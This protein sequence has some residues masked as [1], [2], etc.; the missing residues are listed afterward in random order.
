MR[1][2]RTYSVIKYSC[3]NKIFK[4]SINSKQYIHS[5]LVYV[6]NIFSIYYLFTKD[7]LLLCIII[8]E[9]IYIDYF[10]LINKERKN[11]DKM[12]RFFL[13]FQIPIF[14]SS[15]SFFITHKLIFSLLKLNKSHNYKMAAAFRIPTNK[16][17]QKLSEMRGAQVKAAQWKHL[18]HV[19][20]LS[21]WKN[22]FLV[23]FIFAYMLSLFFIVFFFLSII[24]FLGKEPI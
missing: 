24:D 1:P 3:R 9:F 15:P 21:G 19:P 23:R 5:F 6:S 11:K 2:L 13:F 20:K 16:W 4:Q 12:Y 18:L 7:I 22:W 14:F 17:R 10:C 8:V